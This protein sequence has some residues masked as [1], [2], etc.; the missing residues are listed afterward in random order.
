M[1]FAL[2]TLFIVLTFGCQ[3]LNPLEP[4][5]PEPPTPVPPVV[6]DTPACKAACE[7]LQLLKCE[8]GNPI[9]TNKTCVD[10]LQCDQGQECVTGIC[11]A[12]CETFCEQ[13][14]AQGVWLDPVCVSKIDSCSQIDSCPLKK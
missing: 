5:E 12:H 2:S 14:Q 4:N 7:N 3:A 8:E 1:K 6:V 13:T 10:D 11:V 9:V